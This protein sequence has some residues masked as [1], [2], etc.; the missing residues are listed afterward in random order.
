[1]LN[2]VWCVCCVIFVFRWWLIIGRS[3][4]LRKASGA[5][6]CSVSIMTP[7]SMPPN[8]G[9]WLAS[10]TTAALWGRARTHTHTRVYFPEAE[11][12]CVIFCWKLRTFGSS[13]GLCNLARPRRTLFQPDKLCWVYYSLFLSSKWLMLRSHD[14]SHEAEF[15]SSS[16]Q[17]GMMSFLT[18]ETSTDKVGG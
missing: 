6:T 8:V 12:S 3:D 4:T 16:L 5:A 10:S 9:T 7:S 18:M 13:A 17:V 2:C 1:M 15:V 14:V 11:Q